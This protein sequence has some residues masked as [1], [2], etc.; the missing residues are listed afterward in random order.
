M[1][2]IT[3]AMVNPLS[4]G[5]QAVG[6]ASNLHSNTSLDLKIILLRSYLSIQDKAL[7]T[8]DLKILL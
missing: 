8:K 4:H 5:G 2:M 1:H 7:V 6:D 3:V